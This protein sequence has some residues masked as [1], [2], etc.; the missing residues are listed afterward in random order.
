MKI[1]YIFESQ[2][3]MDLIKLRNVW[4]CLIERVLFKP[5]QVI[6]ME[7]ETA[8]QSQLHQYFKHLGFNQCNLYAN[9]K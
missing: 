2:N 6:K 5:K 9:K 7:A 1:K 8:N 3:H 4:L